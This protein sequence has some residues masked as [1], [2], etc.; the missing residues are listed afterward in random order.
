MAGASLSAGRIVPP[1]NLHVTLAFLGSRPS[2]DLAAVAAA[3]ARPPRTR[4]DRLRV[5]GY[6]ETRSVGMLVLEDDGGRAPA[7][8]ERLQ[9]G[10]RR[11]GCTGAKPP[12][13]PAR[14]GAAVPRPPA[15]RPA[16][17]GARDVVRP[18]L[19]FTFLGRAPA[20]RSTRSA[21]TV[22]LGG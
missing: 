5:R 22:A 4:R 19:L 15:A 3:L 10:S 9:A 1:E 2:E 7:L 20:G 13:A 6:R 21:R 11:L 17:S 14:H 8:A 12:V 16:G 18:T